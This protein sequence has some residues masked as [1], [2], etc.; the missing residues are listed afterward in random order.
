M[1]VRERVRARACVRVCVCF[2]KLTWGRNRQEI[3]HGDEEKG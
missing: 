3:S 1:Y 2:F